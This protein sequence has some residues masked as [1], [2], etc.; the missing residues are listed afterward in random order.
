MELIAVERMAHKLMARHGV[1]AKGW[2]FAFDRATS[3]LGAA[4]FHTKRIT[5]SKYMSAAANAETVEQVLLHEIAHAMLP[6][7]V[8][9][10]AQW[11]ALAASIGY[12][13]KRT[14]ENP[15]RT[16]NQAQAPGI[17]GRPYQVQPVKKVTL[18]QTGI[19]AGDKL[20]LPKIGLVV[21]EKL[22][23]T[24]FHVRAHS[25]GL[26]YGVPAAYAAQYKV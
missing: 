9:H 18:A 2:T 5:L 12:T 4:H 23:R 14:A 3:R 25:T 21:V 19:Q 26:R 16:Q 6:A 10:D 11:K 8:K 15:Y 22:A 20:N 7:N 24:R 13:G 17:Q 1:T